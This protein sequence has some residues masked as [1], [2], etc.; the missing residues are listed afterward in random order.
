MLSW[1]RSRLRRAARRY[2]DA[3]WPVVPG[4]YLTGRGQRRRFD[5][6]TPKCRTV[7][8]HPA[9]P[10]WEHAGSTD[11]TTIDTWWAER[12]YS[13]LLATG[14][15]FDVLDVPAELGR[16]AI[17][18]H[19]PIRGPVA[20]T[21]DG[22]WIFLVRPGHTLLPELEHHP[23]VILH[24]SNSWVPG[25]PSPQVGGA[26]QWLIHPAEYHWRP[27]NPYSVQALM[28]RPRAKVFA[29]RRTSRVA[30]ITEPN[31]AVT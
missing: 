4:A 6:G 31:V 24:G 21:A 13:V 17:C 28:L 22:R 8:C 2:A 19:R 9:I 16:R 23:D 14:V 12:P 25:P 18:A 11:A 3:G 5:C 15:A 30:A 1:Q 27:A 7:S 26:A 10:E 20:T 29:Q